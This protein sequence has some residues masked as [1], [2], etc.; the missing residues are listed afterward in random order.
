MAGESSKAVTPEPG[1]HAEQRCKNWGKLS[2]CMNSKCKDPEV[3]ICLA[4]GSV[5]WRQVAEWGWR[6]D[7]FGSRG[8]LGS[9]HQDLKGHDEVF[10]SYSDGG[11]VLLQW[12]EAEA[13]SNPRVGGWK[14]KKSRN[15]SQATRGPSLNGGS[16]D[17]HGSHTGPQISTYP[18]HSTQPRS[19]KQLLEI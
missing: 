19:W 16:G 10:E 14:S 7:V 12:L 2:R 3:E 5:T 13:E 11:W 18:L 15:T 1:E 17:S 4:N 6:A 9:T 8:G